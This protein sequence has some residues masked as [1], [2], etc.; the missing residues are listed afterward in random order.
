MDNSIYIT[1]TRELAL[2]RDMD[3]TANNIA[4]TNTTGY[5]SEHL[6]FNTYV[7][8]DI[9]QGN[10]NPMAFATDIASYRD[11]TGGSL[12]VTNNDLDVAIQGDGYFIV[13]TP[14][15]QRYTRAGNFQI[16]GTGTLTTP[17]G[18]PV[19]DNS[20]Q[21]IVL[22]ENT[23]TI[24]IGGAGNLKVNGEDFATI[25]VVQFDNQQLLERL[26]GKLFKSKI[27]GQPAQNFTVAQGMLESSNVQPVG[28]MTHMITLSH[29]VA[30]TD[31]F[32]EVIYDLERKASNTWAQ[33]S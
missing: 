16:D 10:Q 7:T 15:G 8:K 33:Q 1:L 19:E 5:S 20:G 18:Y 22:P 2:F 23:K 32:I 14:L 4:N 3:I 31:K 11:T 27:A 28:E 24:Q 9:N 13:D 12:T 21:H 25:N 6:L 29:N 26:N 17:E 30:D